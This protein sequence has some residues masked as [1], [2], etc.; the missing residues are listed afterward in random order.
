MLDA[1]MRPPA[2]ATAAAWAITVASTVARCLTWRSV[3]RD[4]GVVP[5]DVDSWYHVH[6]AGLLLENGLRP[7]GTDPWMGFPWG[8]PDPWPPLFGYLLAAPAFLSGSPNDIAP[9]GAVLVP[10]LGGLS[11]FLTFCIASRFCRPSGALVA[12]TFQGLMPNVLFITQVARTDHHA[13]VAPLTLG[14]YL[15]LMR[16]FDEEQHQKRVAWALG[17]A[18]MAALS[19]GTWPISA[20]L[21]FAPVPLCFL[22]GMFFSPAKQG[23]V[24]LATVV[25]PA[26]ALMVAALVAWWMD[27]ADPLALY[28]L[29]P[30]H[31]FP[32]VAALSVLVVARGRRVSMLF[33]FVLLMVAAGLL[34]S[35][36][37]R[38]QLLSALDVA[39]VKDPVYL[40]ATESHSPIGDETG[41]TLYQVLFGYTPLFLLTPMLIALFGWVHLRRQP[42][43]MDALLM[44]LYA[45][46]GLL[47]MLMQ[48][49]FGEYASPALAVLYGWGIESAV[50]QVLQQRRRL[51]LLP[52]V[53]A[54]VIAAR[55]LWKGALEMA[56]SDPAAL[57][58]RQR[59][60]ARVV[61][62]HTPDPRDADGRPTYGILT[63]W[64]DAAPMLHAAGRAVMVAS[65]GTPTARVSNR[66]AFRIMLTADEETAYRHMRALRMRYLV[67]SVI[68]AQVEAMTAMAGFEEPFVH[69]ETSWQAAGPM[70]GYTLFEPFARAVHTRLFVADGSAR[71]AFGEESIPLGHFR[72]VAEA[73]EITDLSGMAIPEFKL[74]EAVEGARVVGT[75][76]AGTVVQFFLP[77]RTN[78]G[79]AFDYVTA[80]KSNQEGLFELRVPYS[81]QPTL[82]ATTAVE[83]G[84]LHIGSLRLPVHISEIDVMEGREVRP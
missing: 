53:A 14:A 34:T 80:G 35:A 75:A 16:A 31:L 71:M 30:F 11:V 84:S 24:R 81:T 29:S 67:T 77:L 22:L 41:I 28:G 66:Q 6:R 49:R 82:K 70:M 10:L 76:P 57:H 9:F 72:H 74:F 47:L 23:I 27:P 50:S 69:K 4:D 37:L 26:T 25:L 7:Y 32:Y 83:Q 63:S 19:A 1:R 33:G 45:A 68:I 44:T 12:A 65:L 2:W 8:M 20:A 39:R 18:A 62:E 46:A 78:T 43:P 40:M 59:Q 48:V 51:F 15:A 3:F 73:T 21:Y 64:A 52:T 36:S 38:A 60:F 79:R 5:I 58:H 55:P 61:A 54:L 13:A 42:L 17:C 56:R